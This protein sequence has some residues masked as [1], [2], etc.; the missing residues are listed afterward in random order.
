MN[1]CEHCADV[2][3]VVPAHV[4]FCN[5]EASPRRPVW[6]CTSCVTYEMQTAR[7]LPH[8]RYI[9]KDADGFYAHQPPHDNWWC[10]GHPSVQ[11]ARACFLRATADC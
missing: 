7:M 8:G 9:A 2:D 11:D 5:S 4:L 10:S 1:Y 3:E 6:L